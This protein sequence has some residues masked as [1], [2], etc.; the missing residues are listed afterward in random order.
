MKSYLWSTGAESAT[1]TVSEP[2]NYSVKVTDFNNCSNTDT[3]E[4]EFNCENSLYIPNAFTPNDDHVNDV[5]YVRG[6]PRNLS[7]EKM[8]IYDRWGEKIFE[9]NNILPD[10]PLLGWDGTYKSKPSQNEVYAYLVIAKYANGEE[11]KYK[12][13]VTLLR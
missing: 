1:I 3:I 8:I 6:N 12:G 7:I 4:I 13:N 9:A 2:G 11:I 10:D 5:F